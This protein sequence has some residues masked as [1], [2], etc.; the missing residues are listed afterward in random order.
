MEEQKPE[1]ARQLQTLCWKIEIFV[2]EPKSQSRTADKIWR[3]DPIPT[4][5]GNDRN[6]N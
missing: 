6:G 1:I 4:Q 3:S 5:Q 2:Q